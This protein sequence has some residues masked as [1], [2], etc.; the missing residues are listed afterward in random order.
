MGDD[1]GGFVVRGALQLGLDGAFVG[2]VQGAGGF[3]KNQN[4]RV[5]QQGAGN[6]HALLLAAREFEA[7]LAHHGG[8]AL[9]RSAD[10]AVNARRLRC[11]FHLRTAGTGAAI[12]DVVFHRVVKQHGVL[13]HDANGL[14]H[15]GLGD[16]F[17]VLPGYADVALLH[18]VKAVEQPCQGGLARA[19]GA[20]HSHGFASGDFKADVVQNLPAAAGVARLRNIVRKA[21]VFKAHGGLVQAS[22][23][24]CTRCIRHFALFFHEHKHFVQIGQALLDLAVQHTQKIER[25]VELNHE[26]VDHHQVAQ[27]H[28]AIDHA[29]RGT[30]EHGHQAGGDDELLAGVEQG[31]GGLAL[32]PGAAQLPEALVVALGLVGFVVEVFDGLVIE[33]RIDRLGVR[34]GVKLVGLFAVFGAPL[35]DA[36]RERDVQRQ[37]ADGDPRKPHVKLHREVGQYQRHLNQRGDD[38]VKRIRNQRF[39]AAHAALDVACHAAGLPLQ[40]KAQTER[41]QVLKGLQR[42][43]TRRALRGLGEHQLAQFGKQ[44]GGQAQQPVGHDQPQRNDEQGLGVI[45]L[46]AHRIDQML[47]QHRHAH[48]GHLRPHHEQQS[49][50]GPPFV[51][52]QIGKEAF[53]GDPVTARSGG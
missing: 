50:D 38:A 48:V 13:R 9:W 1:Q 4:R 26:G 43:R 41:V 8:V 39:N 46:E 20:D 11:F 23:G 27:R 7:A 35:G 31:E 36:H 40:M 28:A 21:H 16:G 22:E 15:A 24:Q 6:G 45:R 53:E 29:L 12:G 19:R 10:E 47:E 33:Q 44:R 5:F 2:A 51:F 49:G 52:P 34:G 32:E 37:C 18:V 25:D 30:P 17:D 42:N 14:A 3:V